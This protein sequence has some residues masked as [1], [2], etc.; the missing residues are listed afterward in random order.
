MPGFLICRRKRT[1]NPEQIAAEK[2]LSDLQKELAWELSVTAVNVAGIVDPTPISDGISMAMSLKEGDLIG[3]GLSLISMVPYVG[4][5]LSKGAMG[6]RTAKKIVNLQ[7]RI[8]AVTAKIGKLRRRVQNVA[9]VRNT[10]SRAKKALNL[11]P[12]AV[13]KCGRK[14]WPT[15][16]AKKLLNDLQELNKPPKTKAKIQRKRILSEQFG[17]EAAKHQLRRKLGREIPDE[18]IKVF[19]GSHTVNVF[20]KDPATG[21]IYVLEAKG[22]SSHLG[23]RKLKY[24]PNKG[25]RVKQ[26][27]R[28]YLKDVAQSMKRSSDPAKQKAGRE[29][30]N[31]LKRGDV[32]YIGVRGAYD[33]KA[34]AGKL[35]EPKQIFPKKGR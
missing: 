35:I 6:A 29:I 2:E 7:K 4:D 34:P 17:N 14:P 11:K 9:L 21:K 10:V 19:S 16:N 20:H 24:G 15:S 25:R 30:L 32:E 18:E 8:A 13:R 12:R 3:A 27:T 23:T 5:A 26:G 22:G 28:Q 33:K 31:G 1:M